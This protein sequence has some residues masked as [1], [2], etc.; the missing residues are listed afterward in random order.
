MAIENWSPGT[1]FNSAKEL[2][3]LVEESRKKFA[4]KLQEKEGISLSRANKIAKKQIGATWDLGHVNIHK[5]YG[6]TDE[7][8]VRETEAI[9]P[10]LKHLHLTDNFGFSDSHLV[11]GM[12]NV[13]FKEHLEKLE[14]A[15]VLDKVRK[16][17]EAGGYVKDISQ[18]GA[19]GE[20]MAAFSSG[21]YGAKMA[22]YWNQAQG[23]MGSYF[24]GYGATS[25]PTHHNIY[26]AGFT[27]LPTE[28]G[29]TIPG[30]G[31]RFTGNPTA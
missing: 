27:T 22:P 11:P 5:K 26:G 30:G 1:A 3:E 15:G 12:G 16:V 20:T 24:G 8:I 7:D 14:K 25:P 31:S 13:P 17:V 28:L 23:M 18:R 2:K 10:V 21:I 6:L 4:E 29:G 9:A 19:H